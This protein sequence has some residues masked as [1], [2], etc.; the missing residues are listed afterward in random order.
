MPHDHAMPYNLADIF[1]SIVD[2]VPDHPAVV[3][4]RALTYAALDAR[5]SRLADHWRRQGLGAGDHIGLMLYN[6]T[7]YVEAMIAAFKIQAVPVNIN[8][9]YVAAE[10]VYLFDNADLVGLVFEREL[11]EE[12]GRALAEVPGVREVMVT[13]AGQ[14]TLPGAVEYEQ[15]LAAASPERAPAARSGDDRLI[16]YTG[17]T[18]GMPRGV[19][20]RHEDVLFGALQGGA[21]GG[22]PVESAEEIA[23]SVDPD[24]VMILI[25]AAP[26]IHGSSMFAT[27]IALLT[28]GCAVMVPGRSYDAAA[29][30]AL[31]EQEQVSVIALVGDAMA[32]PLV[33]ALEACPRCMDSLAVITS[34]GALLSGD[35][36]AQLTALLPDVMI[37]NNFGTSESGHQGE[38]FYEE[39]GPQARPR[40]VMNERT[41]VLDDDLRPVVPGSGVVGRLA[42]SGHIPLGY[43]NDPEKT[44]R[45]FVEVDGRR[46]VIAGDRATVDEEGIIV[47]LGRGS[48]CI[49]T[50]GEKVYPEEVEEALKS[51]PSVFDA[52]VVG[53]SDPRWGQRVE[54]VL[55]LRAGLDFD[56]AAVTA[57][58]RRRIAGYKAPRRYHLVDAVPRHPNGKPDYRR[59]LAIALGQER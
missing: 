43:Y 7:A 46:W 10:L 59:A 8:Y 49:N 57:A 13:G 18:T 17:G 44:A 31:V 54:A 27:W 14:G 39:D 38:A 58:C 26:L 32:R 56:E 5:A 15:A 20:W 3:C 29:M 6:S 55:Q 25:P 2:V 21:P 34:Q 11:R 47:F 52:L 9:R 35:V 24:N 33:D 42:T 37:L 40:W 36:R 53:A 30:C 19:V 48:Q 12:V 22:L 28:G 41:A 45:T 1:E 16:I 50:G 4:D 23:Q 51:H